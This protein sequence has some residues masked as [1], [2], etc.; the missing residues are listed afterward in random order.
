ML[1][2]DLAC[3]SAP[4]HT[5]GLSAVIISGNLNAWKAAVTS[6][7]SGE[8]RDVFGSIYG[9]F[10]AAGM[11]LSSL[12]CG[13]CSSEADIYP[14]NTVRRRYT[15]RLKSQPCVG[16][17]SCESGFLIIEQHRAWAVYP[18]MVMLTQTKF[19]VTDKKG[20]EVYKPVTLETRSGRIYFVKSPF[21]AKDEI[22]A[23]QGSRWHGF[24][25]EPLKQW[26]VKDC[27]R[28]RLQIEWLEG[29]NP[30]EWFEQPIK[31]F[32]P[33]GYC[34]TS[35]KG[36]K[37]QLWHTQHR[38]INA[39]LT[40]HY[41]LLACCPGAGKT[42]AAF[43]IIE[44]SEAIDWWWV[45]PKTT[46]LEIGIQAEYWKLDK[47]RNVKFM[48][49]EGLTSLIKSGGYDLPQGLIFDEG[50]KLKTEGC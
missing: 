32:L 29:K 30:F 25:E 23:M 48:T 15:L 3:M 44:R 33:E 2:S 7:L 9:A 17:I 8:L 43:E 11:G 6:G 45:G 12:S 5:R 40:F 49:Y 35:I 19:I 46:L 10:S 26:S 34:R 16:G 21:E 38:M 31:S 24:D 42:L 39:G 41:Q 28:N 50:S 1:C 22:K 14:N 37:R 20:R 47:R 13:G 36:E 18:A 27:L 4:T